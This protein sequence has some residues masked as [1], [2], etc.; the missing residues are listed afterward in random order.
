MRLVC[1]AR[2]DGIVENYWDDGI[3]FLIRKGRDKEGHG[4]IYILNATPVSN[5]IIEQQWKYNDKH[6]QRMISNAIVYVSNVIISMRS[7]KES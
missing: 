3:P 7:V 5:D 1:C 4:A 6:I 2:K